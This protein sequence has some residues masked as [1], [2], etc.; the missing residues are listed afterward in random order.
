MVAKNTGPK[1]TAIDTGSTERM[2]C[3]CTFLRTYIAMFFEVVIG[4]AGSRN[5]LGPGQVLNANAFR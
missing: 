2:F 1:V 3:H 5:G 4:P